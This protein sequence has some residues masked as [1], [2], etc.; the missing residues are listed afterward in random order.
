MHR[1]G[2]PTVPQQKQ[3]GY[4]DVFVHKISIGGIAD[5]NAVFIG[6]Q[7]AHHWFAVLGLKTNHRS[8]FFI[9]GHTAHVVNFAAKLH[10]VA[11]VVK[12]VLCADAFERNVGR[13]YF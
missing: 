4:A 5:F 11:N 3:A 7:Q 12:H 6:N 2:W 8:F 13:G 9:G 10:R 1:D